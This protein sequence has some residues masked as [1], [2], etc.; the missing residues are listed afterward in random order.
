MASAFAQLPERLVIVAPENWS[1]EYNG[2]KGIEFYTIK[3]PK[4]DSA[5]LLMLS[6]WP[7]PAKKEEIPQMIEAMAK[8]FLVAVQA[9]K[10]IKDQF[11]GYKIEDIKGISFS[12]QYA[13][14]PS[15]TGMVQTMYMVGDGNGIWN[16]QFTGTEAGWK[17]ALGVLQKLKYKP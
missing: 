6:R 1:I 16:G 3:G 13:F 2:D 4:P 10:A 9:N 8:N 17:E 7:V 11:T 5:E 12:G 14:F 15:K